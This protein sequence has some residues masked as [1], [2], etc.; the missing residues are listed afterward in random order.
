[1]NLIFTL[2]GSQL[3]RIWSHTLP[4]EGDY[5]MYNDNIYTVSKMIWEFNEDKVFIWVNV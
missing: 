4:K 1:M 3:F 2:N 5:I